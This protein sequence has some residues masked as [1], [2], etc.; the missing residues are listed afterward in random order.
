MKTA[1]FSNSKRLIARFTAKNTLRGALWFGLFAGGIVVLQASA[2]VATYPSVAS[3][4][5]LVTAFAGNPALSILYGDPV[6]AGT[7]AG[8]IVF[9]CLNVLLFAAALW[10]LLLATKLFRGQEEEGR[11]ELLLS[12]Q[13]TSGQAVW[14]TLRGW[15]T[16]ALATFVVTSVLVA[17][18]GAS[19]DVHVS[20]AASAY[21]ALVVMLMAVLF[22]S[23]GALTSQLA[24]TRHRATM[25]GLVPL[26]IF[27]TLRSLA[28]LSSNLA[29]LKNLTPFGWLEKANPIIDP[30]PMWLLLVIVVSLICVA[31][32]IF[33]ASRRD[34]GDS[35]IAEQSTSPP[36]YGLLRSPL[37]LA[38][39]L[40]RL[41]LLSWLLCTVVIT[42]ITTSVTKTAIRSLSSDAFSDTLHGLT[43]GTAG[44]SLTFVSVSTLLA[45]IVLLFMAANG[46]GAIRHEESK[47]YLD[48]ILVKAVSRRRWLTGRLV[49]LFG[50]MTVICIISSSLVWLIA[51]A[52]GIAIDGPQMVLEGLNVLGPVAL[53]LGIGSFFYGWRPRIA[54]LAIYIVLLWSF[55]IDTI[56]SVA[57]LSP[58]LVNSSLFG[59]MAMTPVAHP[60]W[61]T[62]VAT[63]SIG[64]VLAGLGI[65]LFEHRD[66]EA[67]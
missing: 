56:S 43:G 41:T 62:F 49:L 21:F 19:K 54:S 39:R 57:K 61:S 22:M 5:Q 14:S 38:F 10:A 60:K 16:T 33:I 11:W 30:Q 12:G 36:H 58:A 9:R 29:W 26:A 24:A 67:E 23:V 45:A 32:A 40:N 2:Y 59:H 31:A 37:A 1:M 55:L 47:T 44:L 8:Y 15:A 42:A 48:T 4:H 20:V 3:R 34:L 35:L 18:V 13:I 6:N 46:V 27:F 63:L 50:A 66:L 53:A 25:Y 7:P 17:G 64:V 52:Q 28:H 65:V 51:R